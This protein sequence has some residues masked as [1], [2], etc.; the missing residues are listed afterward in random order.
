[1][2]KKKKFI[3]LG[4]TFTPKCSYLVINNFGSHITT[5]ALHATN[6][7]IKIH[8][9]SKGLFNIYQKGLFNCNLWCLINTI[10]SY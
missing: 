1:M 10:I 4:D 6:W 3:E 9:K 2:K 8:N 7:Y 5:P